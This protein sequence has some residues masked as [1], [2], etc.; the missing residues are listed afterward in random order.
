MY[1]FLGRYLKR[2]TQ[3]IEDRD[4]TKNELAFTDG[5]NRGESY[6][7]KYDYRRAVNMEQAQTYISMASMKFKSSRIRDPWTIDNKEEFKKR[8]EADKDMEVRYLG[9]AIYHIGLHI[10][11]LEDEIEELKDN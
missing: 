1:R 9:E 6:G 3:F 4:R 10:A 8:R 5:F 2:V 7:E 11:E